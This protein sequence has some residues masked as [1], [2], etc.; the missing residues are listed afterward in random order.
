M[1]DNDI[2]PLAKRLAEENNV[3][4]RRLEGSGEGGKIVERDVLEYLARVMSGQEDL[5]PTPEP[6][7]EGMEE[8]P[9]EDIAAYRRGARERAEAADT[10][11]PMPAS[12]GDAAE[13]DDF[14][15]G[16]F[17]FEDEDVEESE[18]MGG[19]AEPDVFAVSGS[20]EIEEDDDLFLDVP[21]ASRTE[22]ATAETDSG[23]WL[24]GE[25]LT[26]ESG[27]EE[28][29]ESSYD[30]GAMAFDLDEPEPPASGG[31]A[32]E[33]RD[34]R[35]LDVIGGGDDEAEPSTS[36]TEEAEPEAAGV[37]T[38]T[39]ISEP[40]VAAGEIPLVRYGHLLRRHVDLT[41][42]ENARA[43]L[44]RELGLDEPISLSILLV[45]AAGK[46]MGLHPLGAG[47]ITLA[48]IEGGLGFQQISAS[49]DAS[50]RSLVGS[51]DDADTVSELP[52]D[53][54]L[55]VVDLS[56]W[57]VDEAVLNVGC[58]VLALGRVVYDD[59]VGSVRGTLSLSGDV[60]LDS[61]GRLLA[62]V[63]DLLSA[64]VRL[65]V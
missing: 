60:S 39:P 54:S 51:V 56:E 63:A 2:S 28:P 52:G 40:A 19:A 47:D 20:D 46:A 57:G 3:E 50:F 42:V 9:E 65:V 1:T 8:W 22:A 6:T 38:R 18:P 33:R 43:A 41:D 44:G 26:G 62:A 45:R 53:T 37:V 34:V 55:V 31:Y 23:G 7:P 13:E 61:G 29:E 27:E 14:D 58:P 32:V 12:H 21:A 10:A 25:S 24:T 64:P 36:P 5:D 30:I 48:T 17:L 16:I 11:P 4:W 35:D 49:P 59:E 15:E